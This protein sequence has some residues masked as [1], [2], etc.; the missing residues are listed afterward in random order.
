ME[1]EATNTGPSTAGGITPAEPIE[2][3]FGTAPA[4]LVVAFVSLLRRAG[5]DVPLG[6]TIAFSEALGALGLDQRDHVY[7]A[8]RATLVRRPEDVAVF[9]RVFAEF[10]DIQPAVQLNRM[11]EHVTLEVDSLEDEEGA[12]GEQAPDDEDG[13]RRT[14]RYSREEI[15]RQQDFSTYTEA[16]W[17]E[18]RRLMTE[19]KTRL[20]RR[21]SRRL[22]PV[23]GVG[24]MLDLSRTVRAALASDGEA[25]RR[26]WRTNAVR[27]RRVVFL[28]DISGSM[29]A[30]ARAFLRLAHVLVVSQPLGGAEAFVLGTRMTRLTRQLS[31]RDPDVAMAEAAAAVQDWYGGTRLG[32]GLQS[33][34][35][36][37]GVR[38]MARG[39]T[40]VV[41]SDGWDRGE[42]ESLAREMARLKRVA[43]RIAW[44]NPL[45]SSPGYEPLARGMAAALP[46]VDDFVDGNSLAAFEVLLDVL[47]ADVRRRPATS[48]APIPPGRPGREPQPVARW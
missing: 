40:V 10:F 26:A 14:L 12:E 5:V 9:D 8:A 6:S 41:F 22:R 30:Y 34:N 7:W 20:E 32:D 31:S 45:R 46:F 39:A 16:E 18:A 28:I 38:G 35:D 23:A 27:P 36:R 37:W 3:N 44:V 2:G 4:R 42:P 1:P 43:H 25:V 15:L 24:E 11:V 17:A 21:R 33:F 48:R 47:C 19:L 29:Q 13:S